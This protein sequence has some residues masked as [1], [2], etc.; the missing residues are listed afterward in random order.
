MTGTVRKVI[1]ES[2]HLAGIYTFYG[3]KG[4]PIYIGKA[5]DLNSRLTSYLSQ[6]V[7]PKTHLMLSQAIKLK[8]L[9]VASEL[10]ALILEA[11]QIRKYQPKYNSQ[12]KDDKSPIY[13]IFTKEAY[14]RIFI[15]RK[16]SILENVYK[17]LKIGVSFGPFSSA[18]V[19]RDV[20]K[21]LRRVFP[22]CQQKVGKRPCIYSQI[23]LCSP[24]PSQIENALDTT[25]RRVMRLKYLGN[26]K[27]LKRMLSGKS[28]TVRRELEVLMNSY[29]KQEKYEEAAAVLK[30]ITKFD[31]ITAPTTSTEGYLEN[32]N[33]LSD[34]RENE[35][36]SLRNFLLPNLPGIKRLN[37]IECYDV[38]HLAGTFPTSSMVTFI[39]GE[40]AKGYYRHFRIR[41]DSSKD[42]YAM[43]SETIARRVK[44]LSDWGR[45]DLV[46]VDG[47]KGQVTSAIAILEKEGI[48]VIGL[49]KRFEIVVVR[50]GDRFIEEKVP[51]GA[52]LNL[53]QRIRNE[54]HRFARRYHHKLVTTNLTN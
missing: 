47:G 46:I 5:K 4:S 17:G 50:K 15:V 14:P 24:C 39:G 13:I 18:R 30:Q 33:L 20:L 7:G 23:G 35:L 25:K 34:I 51:L 21:L 36:T 1:K 41:K 2:P 6:K 28:F 52:S 26:I 45:P 49:A 12:S 19:A 53:L 10:E 32:P 8:Y 22:F 16:T 27:N 40:S 29:S 54:A 44:H 48:P 38:A 9:A 11:Y 42:D 3:Q 31:E 43:I 37:R